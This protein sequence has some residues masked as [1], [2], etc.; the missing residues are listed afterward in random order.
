MLVVFVFEL[1]DRRYA[2]D[3]ESGCRLRSNA[4][5]TLNISAQRE[6]DLCLWRAF[7]GLWRAFN[8]KVRSIFFFVESG[9]LKEC[10]G[11]FGGV[12]GTE[13]FAVA[14]GFAA[15]ATCLHSFA[16]ALASSMATWALYGLLKMALYR[17]G[18]E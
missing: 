17:S 5:Q 15:V 7:Q 2:D 9:V 8:V 12:S 1:L 14:P 3:R 10:W 16:K 13:G 18:C 4:P 6:M 11:L